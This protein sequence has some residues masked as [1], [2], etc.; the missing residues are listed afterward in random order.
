M[1]VSGAP[2][3]WIWPMLQLHEMLAGL[4]GFVV[5]SLVQGVFAPLSESIACTSV[6]KALTRAQTVKSQIKHN[7]RLHPKDLTP[8]L[9]EKV[10]SSWA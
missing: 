4:P 7:H 3:D 1:M 5:D 10:V 6:S 9:M 8:L 2:K